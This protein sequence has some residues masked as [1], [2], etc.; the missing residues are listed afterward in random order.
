MNYTMGDVCYWELYL[1]VNEFQTKHPYVQGQNISKVYFYLNFENINSNIQLYLFQGE[2][3]RNATS[4]SSSS[5]RFYNLSVANGH[6][7]VIAAYPTSS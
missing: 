2:S 3:R 1:D 5:N 4:I 7:V 6:K